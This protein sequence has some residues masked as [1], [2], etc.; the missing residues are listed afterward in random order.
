MFV[1]SACF[2]YSTHRFTKIIR[3]PDHFGGVNCLNPKACQQRNLRSCRTANMADF[4]R[5]PMIIY[6]AHWI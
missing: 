4:L 3:A 6:T 2:I 5:P 1:F